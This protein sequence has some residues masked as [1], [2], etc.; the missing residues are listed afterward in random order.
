MS[1]LPSPPPVRRRTLTPYVLLWVALAGL[2]A[3]YLTFLGVH[4]DV[5]AALR[6]AAPDPQQ[7]LDETKQSVERALADLDPLRQSVGEIKTDI[8]SLKIGAQEGAD[9]D[10]IL[11]E[12]VE[13][14][15]QRTAANAESA[16]A[17]KGPVIASVAQ[18]PSAPKKSVAESAPAGKGS[19]IASVPPPPSAPKK[20]AAVTVPPANVAVAEPAAVAPQLVQ[21]TADPKPATQKPANAIVTG[22]IARG[23]KAAAAA[24]TKPA[25]VGIL[26][27]TGP[28]VDAL[29]LSWTILNDRHAD[30]VH[31]L[32]PRYV[33]S[34]KPEER[35]YGLVAGPFDT[36][37]DAQAVCKTIAD[38]GMPCELSVYRG[39][40]L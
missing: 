6:A 23:T 17:G 37:A 5:V 12:K 22:S 7:A 27:A 29:R 19:V 35:T 4:P 40:Q 24:A 16:Q 14:L 20:S 26:L 3:A 31:S 9:R 2:S 18:P 34:G 15:E 25:P 28:S 32:H 8:A 33:V 13:V 1:A 38:G 21:E 10:R 36:I 30:A 39:N 11:L